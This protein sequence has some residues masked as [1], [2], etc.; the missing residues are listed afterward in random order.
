MTAV[1]RSYL[2]NTMTPSVWAL[3][4]DE[5]PVAV[6]P[7]PPTHWRLDAV[8]PNPFNPVV[9][10][11]YTVPAGAAGHTVA[12]YDVGGRRGATLFAGERPPGA[13]ALRWDGRDDAGRRV[14]SGVYLLQVE[15]DGAASLTRKLVLLK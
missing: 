2:R 12:V 14:P 8:Y 11:R 9:N 10:V 5:S 3:L 4:I 7:P 15:P 1:D 13:A 6:E